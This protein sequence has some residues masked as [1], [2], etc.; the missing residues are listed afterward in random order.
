MELRESDNALADAI[1]RNHPGDCRDHPVQRDVP[2]AGYDLHLF[3]DRADYESC[4][5]AVCGI[6]F[7][8]W[9]VAGHV[10]L[11][12]ISAGIRKFPVKHHEVGFPGTETAEEIV[13]TAVVK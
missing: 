11:P 10:K 6:C 3:L 1:C 4:D 8:Y 5:L 12:H 9:N 13:D 2:E 7:G